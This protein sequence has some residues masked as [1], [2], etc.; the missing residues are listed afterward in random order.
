MPEEPDSS[1]GPL[2][3]YLIRQNLHIRTRPRSWDYEYSCCISK[4]SEK[5]YGR[6]SAS[7]EFQCAKLENAQENLQNIMKKTEFR[8]FYMFSPTFV[9]NLVT[10]S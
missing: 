10:L 3:A 9:P 8:L 6:E 4:L 2:R 1:N 5:D 7:G